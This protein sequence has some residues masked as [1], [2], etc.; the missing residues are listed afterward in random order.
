M[1]HDQHLERRVPGAEAGYYNVCVCVRLGHVLERPGG[2][3]EWGQGWGEPHST[4][5]IYASHN[6]FKVPIKSYLKAEDSEVPG[7]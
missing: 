4:P 3:G 2:G 1:S 6:W 5:Y 7:E